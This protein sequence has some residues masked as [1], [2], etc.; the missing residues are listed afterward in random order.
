MFKRGNVYLVQIRDATCSEQDGARPAII[1]SNN[2]GN[3]Y[4]EVIEVVY[5]TTKPKTDLP[6]HVPISLNGV[7]STALC[8]QISSIAKQRIVKY[9]GRVTKNELTEVNAALKVSLGI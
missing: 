7:K 1:V 9:M 6:T 5:L 8:E 3:K 2:R 4:S